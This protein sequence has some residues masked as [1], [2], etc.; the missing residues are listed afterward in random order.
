MPLAPVGVHHRPRS[1]HS[2]TTGTEPAA[3]A[4]LS[5]PRSRSDQPLPAYGSTAV[6]TRSPAR[7]LSRELSTLSADSEPESE[8]ANGVHLQPTQWVSLFSVVMAVARILFSMVYTTKVFADDVQKKAMLNLQL[9][10][11]GAELVT[12]VITVVVFFR[13][14]R[15]VVRWRRHASA[16]VDGAV[17]EKWWSDNAV[18]VRLVALL[19][20]VKPAVLSVLMSGLIESLDTP[21]PRVFAGWRYGKLSI[22]LEISL[23][24]TLSSFFPPS[25]PPSLPPS[26]CPLVLFLYLRGL[27]VCFRRAWDAKIRV[28]RRWIGDGGVRWRAAGYVVLE[29]LSVQCRYHAARGR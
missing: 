23:L 5:P 13:S 16:L 21:L 6:A 25:L 7:Q 17:L 10:A 1:S 11:I 15:S 2:G 28:D 26:F 4:L 18:V 3:E 24:P 14:M 12:G 19:A 20:V 8:F 9:A 22:R 29:L 27:L